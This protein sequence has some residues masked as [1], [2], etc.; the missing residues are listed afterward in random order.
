[1]MLDPTDE[2]STCL[3]DRTQR[4]Q[5]ATDMEASHQLPSSLSSGNHTCIREAKLSTLP[6]VNPV[7]YKN[8]CPGKTYPLVQS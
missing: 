5:S 6:A 3:S 4:H 7:S 2:D 1:M 8:D